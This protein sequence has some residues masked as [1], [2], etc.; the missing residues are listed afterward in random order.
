MSKLAKPLVLVCGCALVASGLLGCSSDSSGGASAVSCSSVDPDAK[1]TADQSTCYP[2]NDGLISGTYTVAIAVND[3]GFTD[4]ALTQ[5]SGSDDD[6]DGAGG[7][8]DAA[9]GANDGSNAKNIIATQNSAQITLTLTNTGTKPHGF[10]V[11]CVSVCSSYPT[12]PAGCSSQACFPSG[13]TI[14]PIDPGTSKTVTFLTPVPDNL[15]YP[16]SSSAPDDS[17]VPGLNQGQWSLM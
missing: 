11:S 5:T 6:D 1:P 8:D 2:D 15:L 9:G 13:A 16:F 4:T 7:A 10:Q 17:S 3:T 14:D 12:L